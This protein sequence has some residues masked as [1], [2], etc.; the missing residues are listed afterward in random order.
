MQRV[1][2]TDLAELIK[3]NIEREIAAIPKATLEIV[4]KN[5]DKEHIRKIGEHRWHKCIVSERDYFE[6][7][8]IHI[9]K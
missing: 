2:D 8:N 6:G 3:A 5:A 9:D 4:M 7:D 1:Q